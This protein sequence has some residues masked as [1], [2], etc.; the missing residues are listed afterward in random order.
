MAEAILIQLNSLPG[1]GQKEREESSPGEP[2]PSSLRKEATVGGHISD[3]GKACS[4]IL[5]M[6]RS[7][8]PLPSHT[9]SQEAGAACVRVGTEM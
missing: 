9:A 5:F 3:G 1:L 6:A 4:E 8:T 2:S 7:M